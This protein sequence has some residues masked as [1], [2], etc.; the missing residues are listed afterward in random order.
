M[1]LDLGVPKQVGA[2]SSDH[3]LRSH[4][5]E[6]HIALSHWIGV[7][8][9]PFQVVCLRDDR[10][11]QSFEMLLLHVII[12]AKKASPFRV[13]LRAGEVVYSELLAESTSLYQ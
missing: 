4:H 13:L 10:W 5:A 3:E 8:R 6:V 2:K 11:L 9:E 7:L 12:P 1:L